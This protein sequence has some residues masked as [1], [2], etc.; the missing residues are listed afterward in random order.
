MARHRLRPASRPVGQDGPR[1]SRTTHHRCARS[2]TSAIRRP[3]AGL[4][5]LGARR[6]STEVVSPPG[7]GHESFGSR[8]RDRGTE[9]GAGRCMGCLVH[10]VPSTSARACRMA[11]GFGRGAE[12]QGGIPAAGSELVTPGCRRVVGPTRKTSNQNRKAQESIERSGVGNNTWR[13]R[14]PRRSKASKS[15]GHWW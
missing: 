12:E 2:R 3:H 6:A 4:P 5:E 13:R 8:G 15:H 1:S 9:Q 11:P 7:K 14:T 10:H